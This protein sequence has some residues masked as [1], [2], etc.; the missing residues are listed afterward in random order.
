[1]I[2]FSLHPQ[3]KYKNPVVVKVEDTIIKRLDASRYSG[4]TIDK[5][6]KWRNYLQHIE[7]KMAARTG[8]LRYLSK[9]VYEPNEKTMIKI[10]KL[11]VRTVIMYGFPVLLT[12]KD[13][14]RVR[15]RV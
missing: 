7:A 13:K 9:S 14:V 15:V 4:L 2:H 3:K 10:F 11:I 8:L 6:L 12:A 5:Q 1:M